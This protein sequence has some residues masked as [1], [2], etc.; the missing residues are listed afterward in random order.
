MKNENEQTVLRLRS[1]TRM[2]KLV[3]QDKKTIG[4]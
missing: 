4:E 3:Q 2:L 1:A